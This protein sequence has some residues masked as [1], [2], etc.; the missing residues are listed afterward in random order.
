MSPFLGNLKTPSQ[1]QTAPVSRARPDPRR[2]R[3]S[4]L[5][6]NVV[7][8]LVILV[9]CA[10]TVWVTPAVRRELRESFTR[11]PSSYT[12]LYFPSAPSVEQAQVLVPISVV[13]HG[14]SERT[15]RLRVWLESSDGRTTASTATTLAGRL[16]A[17]VSTVVHLPLPRGAVT[18]HVRLLD[19]SETLHFRLSTSSS[20]NSGGTR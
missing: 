14:D 19:H 5:V 16:D 17:P 15:Y 6:R 11:L 12:E 18:V 2:R 8:L 1:H 10:V 20:R 7:V 13:G 9:V 4:V 3:H